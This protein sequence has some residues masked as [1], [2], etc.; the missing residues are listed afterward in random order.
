MS[1]TA[2]QAHSSTLPAANEWS[3]MLSMAETLVASGLLPR[4]ITKPAAAVAIIQ[5]GKE[6]GVPPMHA[7]SNI[8]VVEGKPTCSAELMLALVYRDHGDN[9]I[10]IVETDNQHCLVA[11]RRRGWKE[12]STYSF[13]MQDAA[14]AGVAG[15]Q[16][17]K[18]YPAA[19]LRAR[20]I[21]AVA[22]MA[23]PDSIAGMFVPEELGAE[24][25]EDGT[26]IH[27]AS[28]PTPL[29]EV[30]PP[31]TPIVP[32]RAAPLSA[33][34]L[35]ASLQPNGADETRR[36][37]VE[38]GNARGVPL[39]TEMDAEA[40]ADLI[41]ACLAALSSEVAVARPAGIITARALHNALVAL[42][43]RQVDAE[44]G[45][46]AQGAPAEGD[47]FAEVDRLVDAGLAAQAAARG[48][49]AE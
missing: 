7:L 9:A 11:Y 21:S 12:Q 14:T 45:D 41:D 48:E 39:T 26:P 25:T 40:M 28:E 5:K 36:K 44:T 3:T 33:P 1:S 47:D 27:V 31:S 35:K 46:A 4:H 23:F 13:T 32:E 43:P 18:S 19:M 20:C 22:R 34:R 2:L 37:L 15:K 49:A 42:P 17:W 16:T 10:Q 38:L 29:R 6:I 8:F 24:V 30:R